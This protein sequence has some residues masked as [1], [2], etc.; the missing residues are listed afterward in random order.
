MLSC[1]L[2]APP[3]SYKNSPPGR[4]APYFFFHFTKLKPRQRKPARETKLRV[5]EPPPEGGFMVVVEALV[6]V[7]AVEDV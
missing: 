3:P 1:Y 5:D 2:I 6:A 7:V 4:E